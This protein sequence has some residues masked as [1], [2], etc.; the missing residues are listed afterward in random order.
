MTLSNEQVLM[1]LGSLVGCIVFMFKLVQSS[2]SR[3]VD[4]LRA[5]CEAR[6]N[7]KDETILWLK[8][9]LRTSLR[10]TER[11]TSAAETATTV[12]KKASEG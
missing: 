11:A 3:E 5:A 6:V 8:E 9:E 4:T 10:T 1:G 7:E 12:A 2:H